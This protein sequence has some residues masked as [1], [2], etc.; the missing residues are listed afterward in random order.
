VRRSRD[1]SQ[2]QWCDFR[3]FD[4]DAGRKCLTHPFSLLSLAR[5]AIHSSKTRVSVSLQTDF[6]ARSR[7]CLTHARS[8]NRRTTGRVPSS[9]EFIRVRTNRVM[10]VDGRY[11]PLFCL[12]SMDQPERLTVEGIPATEHEC[13][14]VRPRS[15]SLRRIR[16]CRRRVECALCRRLGVVCDFMSASLS[17]GDSG[18]VSGPVC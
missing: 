10:A 9:F 11:C 3:D 1:C 17:D 5:T 15:T 13:L 6:R 7:S 14:P 4:C 12:H 2:Q 8:V 18:A 16:E